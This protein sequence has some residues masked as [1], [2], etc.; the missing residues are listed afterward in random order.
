MSP[1]EQLFGFRHRTAVNSNYAPGQE[2][3]LKN[4][5]LK[6]TQPVKYIV[7]ACHNAAWVQNET[8]TVLASLAPL[9]PVYDK[10]EGHLQT[11]KNWRSKR[12]KTKPNKLAY[13]KGANAMNSS[14]KK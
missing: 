12:T 8:R 11:A 3:I 2:F 4:Q 13:S 14:K 9:E 5:K 7:Q 1:A 10:F 6:Q